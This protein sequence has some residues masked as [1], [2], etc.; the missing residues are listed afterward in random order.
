MKFIGEMVNKMICIGKMVNKMN[1]TS[2][3]GKTGK[4]SRNSGSLEILGNPEI[5]RFRN[6]QN[7]EN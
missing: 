4:Q 2:K 6:Y 7:K 3:I 1:L 5:F